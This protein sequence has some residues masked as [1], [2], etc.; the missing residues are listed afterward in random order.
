MGRRAWSPTTGESAAKLTLA[1][2]NT[3]IASAEWGYQHGGLNSAMRKDEFQHLVWLEA[4]RERL[5]GIAAPMR[6]PHRRSLK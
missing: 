3:R 6:K 5:Y 2:L 1:E 4:E